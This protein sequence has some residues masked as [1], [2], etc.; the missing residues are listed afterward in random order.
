MNEI[1][2]T[3]NW[4]KKLDCRCFTSIRLSDRYKVGDKYKIVLKPGRK[5]SGDMVI[6]GIAEILEI[7]QFYLVQLN[8]FIAYLD[9]GYSIAECRKIIERMYPNADWGKQ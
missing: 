4:N 5:L 6:K 1:V 8:T 2:F 9:T 3:Y 7:K